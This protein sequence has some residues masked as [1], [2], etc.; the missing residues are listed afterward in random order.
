MTG[1]EACFT[2]QYRCTCVSSRDVQW[3]FP[4]PPLKPSDP[5]HVLLTLPKLTP[6][7]FLTP[8]ENTKDVT[9]T[10]SEITL[11]TN[12][13]ES[14]AIAS[15][16]PHVLSQIRQP[17]TRFADAM[18]ITPNPNLRDC[19]MWENVSIA[20]VIGNQGFGDWKGG[21]GAGA[22]D[23]AG[24]LSLGEQN[25]VS[26]DPVGWLSCALPLHVNFGRCG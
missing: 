15:Q 20:S 16:C 13:A 1:G 19:P 4:N 6:P 25:P 23:V 17:P 26:P 10:C 9:G 11:N 8:R 12:H 5:S 21:I 7:F 2:H 3:K 18:G 22:V 24:F 14:S